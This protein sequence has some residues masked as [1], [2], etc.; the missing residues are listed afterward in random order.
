VRVLVLDENLFWSVRLSRGLVAAGHEPVVLAVVPEDWPRADAAIV[1]LG[2]A[3]F[4]PKATVDALR[5]RGILVVGHAGHKEK[6]LLEAGDEA[7]CHLVV[8]NSELT[9]RLA[10]VLRRLAEC[11]D[12]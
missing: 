4:E 6:P 3:V 5:E 11:R 12:A 9:H 8:T 1:N 2:S 7:G 10:D